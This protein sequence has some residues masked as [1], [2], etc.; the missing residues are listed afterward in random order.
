MKPS[1]IIS[2]SVCR[3]LNCTS[4]SDTVQTLWFPF[5]CVRFASR[6][7]LRSRQTIKARQRDDEK[8][9][10]WIAL[11]YMLLATAKNRF[12]CRLFRYSVNVLDF[13][14]SVHVEYYFWLSSLFVISLLH[15]H[16]YIH[17]QEYLFHL[18]W[19]M[20]RHTHAHML[21]FDSIS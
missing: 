5:V 20:L 11:H 19:C 3:D 4:K 1:D 12:F 6:L 14:L 8:H 15:V 7:R 9:N 2:F 13:G 16:S 18:S 17:A 10:L 21:G